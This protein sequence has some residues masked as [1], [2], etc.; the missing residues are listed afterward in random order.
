MCYSESGDSHTAACEVLAESAEYWRTRFED[1]QADA[2]RLA[3]RLR[4]RD[5]RILLLERVIARTAAL[6]HAL[7]DSLEQRLEQYSE[8]RE[9][10]VEPGR[11]VQAPSDNP[12]SSVIVRLPH[13]TRTLSLLFEV[14]WEHWAQWDPERPPK[15]STVARSIDAKL[16]LK[17]QAD[18][19]TSRNAQSFAA[20]LRPDSLGDADG[21]HR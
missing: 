9:H 1:A 2:S 19:E 3:S 17:G 12:G 15:S 10:T 11:S 6:H 5:Q 14:M 8:Q 16:G 7:E 13:L 18:G 20:A 4:G 21:R